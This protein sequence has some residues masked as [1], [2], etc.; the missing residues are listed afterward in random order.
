MTSSNLGRDTR[1][2]DDGHV[3][4]VEVDG[5][6]PEEGDVRITIECPPS[7]CKGPF[8]ACD[9]CSGS[10]YEIVPDVGEEPCS[11][12]D[13]SGWADGRHQCWFAAGVEDW[14]EALQYEHT[15]WWR[16]GRYRLAYS[17]EGHYDDF[18][19]ALRR[20]ESLASAGHKDEPAC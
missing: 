18:H 6:A 19:T 2:T 12:C 10:G 9:Q 5:P 14:R 8:L 1:W 13:E 4:V 11:V 3:L 20:G 17:C 15:D 7:G 16:P